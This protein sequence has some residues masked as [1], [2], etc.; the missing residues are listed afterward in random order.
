[1][2][3]FNYTVNYIDIILAAILLVFIIAGY[4]R[5]L[6]INIVNFIRWA[7]GLFLCFLCGITH[8]G[9]FVLGLMFIMTGLAIMFSLTKELI[10]DTKRAKQNK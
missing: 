8:A 3:I 1:M 6:F 2:I 5:G 9:L 10:S 4:C 7:V